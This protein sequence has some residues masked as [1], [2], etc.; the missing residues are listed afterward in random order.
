VHS[1]VG[2]IKHCAN[3]LLA[4]EINTFPLSA[5]YTEFAE[6]R[7]S[8]E[9]Q[10]EGR[11]GAVSTGSA[12]W[13]NYTPCFTEETLELFRKLYSG[14]ETEVSKPSCETMNYSTRKS[15]YRF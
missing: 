9:G 6:R 2:H 14:N 10:W 8:A 1:A 12:G 7:C 15:F 13:T 4:N 3:D 11:P 5:L